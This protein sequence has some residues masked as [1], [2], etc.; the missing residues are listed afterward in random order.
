MYT[1]RLMRTR[2]MIWW[3]YR[4]ERII[5]FIV[6]V[7]FLCT[8][9]ITILVKWNEIWYTIFLF[10][11]SPFDRREPVLV[12]V[13]TKPSTFGD[14][15]MHFFPL[16]LFL[17]RNF[18]SFGGIVFMFARVNFFLSTISL[19]WLPRLLF[20]SFVHSSSSSIYGS[21]PHC[22]FVDALREKLLL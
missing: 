16:L 19:G 7:K 4:G 22:D 2:K 5:T 13:H 21:L 1:H 11:R 18:F 20:C 10:D 14:F 6:Q 3:V 9:T 15:V 12:R 17:R 8:A